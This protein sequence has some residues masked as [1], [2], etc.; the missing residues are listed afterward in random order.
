MFNRQLKKDLLDQ[1]QELNRLRALEAGM[2]AELLVLALDRNMRITHVNAKFVSMMRMD[3]SNLVGR[4]LTDFTP[5]Y[6][7]DLPCFKNFVHAMNTGTTTQDVYRF[8]NG[9]GRLVWL[10]GAWNPTKGANGEV[11]QM[12]C[13][14]SDVTEAMDTAKENEALIQ[15]LLRST[16]VIEFEPS[17]KILTANDHFLK[18]VG[19]S[20]PQIAGKH[21][22]MFCDPTYV[23]SPEY[24]G[25]WETLNKGLFVADRFKRIDS[26][27]RELW[28]EATYNPVHD[29]QGKLHKIVK[30]ATVVTEQIQREKEV[31]QAASTAYEISQQTDVSANRGAQVVHD[32][33]A[34][35]NSIA[36][37]MSSAAVGIEALGE[38]SLLISSIVQTIGGIAQQT[39]LLALNAAIEAARAGEQGRGFAVVADEV[40]QLAG[41]T[42]AATEEIVAVVQK[43]QALVDDAVTHIGGSRAQAEQGLEL[44][45]QAGTV[46]VEIQTGARK[47]VSA[48]EQF[49]KRL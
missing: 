11:L 16:A 8:I 32:T 27:G 17:G 25:F 10:R 6:V 7:K 23:S 46:I 12:T 9:E 36:Q 5:A 14:G 4:S 20:M 42:S 39:N 18:A 26:Q 24:R 22:S 37:Q 19:Y 1:Q 38:Q 34:T 40:R 45:T 35:M 48:V 41:R 47:V 13:Y 3:E 15:A 33:V 30:F 29:T 2:I 49:A 28:L 43:N 44:A 31:S 21:H